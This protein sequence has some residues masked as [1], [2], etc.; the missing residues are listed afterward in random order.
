MRWLHQLTAF[1]IVSHFMLWNRKHTTNIT[2]EFLIFSVS[3]TEIHFMWTTTW[4][5]FM[6][7]HFIS[8]ELKLLQIFLAASF[9]PTRHLEYALRCLESFGEK[10]SLVEKKGLVLTGRRGI[11]T[12]I[13]TMIWCAQRIYRCYTGHMDIFLSLSLFPKTHVQYVDLLTIHI[14]DC[15]ACILKR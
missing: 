7:S 12:M 4:A 11:L 1:V 2:G 5:C 6:F 10:N 15:M 13:Q 8:T 3:N 9:C 14:C